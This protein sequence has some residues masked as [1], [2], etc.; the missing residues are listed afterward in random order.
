MPGKKP[1][2]LTDISDRTKTMS[3]AIA[4][5]IGTIATIGGAV[6]YVE[7]NYAHAND[8]KT[9]IRNQSIQTR[10][11]QLF[12]LD[13]YDHQ[14]KKLETEKRLAEEILTDPKMTRNQRVY[15]RKPADIEEEISEFKSRKETLKK[16]LVDPDTK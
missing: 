4:S 2:T 16:Q 7:N 5:I 13:Y 8:V 6:L 9:V 14:I 10:Q 11:T 3:T 12:Q 15:T 1:D